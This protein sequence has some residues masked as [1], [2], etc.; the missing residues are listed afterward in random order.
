MAADVKE[1][2]NE[3]SIFVDDMG[4]HIMFWSSYEDVVMHCGG[5]ISFLFFLPSLSNERRFVFFMV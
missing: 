3:G 1:E 5:L 2:M 4:S